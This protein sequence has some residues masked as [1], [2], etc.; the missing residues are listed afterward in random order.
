MFWWSEFQ[1]C[2]ELLLK[3]ASL[4]P[5]TDPVIN[6]PWLFSLGS[7]SEPDMMLVT[8]LSSV[9]WPTETGAS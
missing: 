1:S 8:S 5:S 6:H 3:A 7:Q 9:L 2:F 4:N